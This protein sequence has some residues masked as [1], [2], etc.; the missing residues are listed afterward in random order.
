MPD[1]KMK[2]PIMADS[3]EGLIEG[4]KKIPEAL[5]KAD[6]FMK[7]RLGDCKECGKSPCKCD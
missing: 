1:K 7:A 2:A 5:S 6:E 4:A 3:K